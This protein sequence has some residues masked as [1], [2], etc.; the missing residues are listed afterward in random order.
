[1]LS[2]FKLKT[3]LCGCVC[4]CVYG[5]CVWCVC[6][7]VS[8]CVMCV[9]CVWCVC[10]W[11][12]C[13]CVCVWVCVCEWCVCGVCGV[14]VC[15]WVSVCTEGSRRASSI[16]LHPTML[17]VSNLSISVQT[18]RGHLLQNVQIPAFVMKSQT[19]LAVSVTITVFW[20]VTPC[21]FGVCQSVFWLQTLL[22][23]RLVI[24]RSLKPCW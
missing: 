23:T 5:V 21:R 4:V 16:S 17:K 19:Q 11:C 24:C 6:V 18:V 14:C 13:V 10:V 22:L 9:W 1:M 3:Y 2:L 20:D 8:V 12:V 15:V 7:W